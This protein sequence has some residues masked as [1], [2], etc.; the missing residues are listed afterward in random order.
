IRFFSSSALA[1]AEKLRLAANCSAAETMV[2]APERPMYSRCRALSAGLST[3]HGNNARASQDRPPPPCPPP[4]AGEG[5]SSYPPPLAE[6]GR[7][8]AFGAARARFAPP[9]GQSGLLRRQSRAL[10]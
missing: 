1:S 2:L 4:Q 5:K 3:E 6:E 9:L 7:V 8:G 10:R